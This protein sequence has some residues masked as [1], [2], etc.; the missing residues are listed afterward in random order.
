VKLTVENA[1]T[2][3]WCCKK[4]LW[5]CNIFVQIYVFTLHINWKLWL[6]VM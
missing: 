3:I 4:Y 5:F 1:A 2:Q 6:Y